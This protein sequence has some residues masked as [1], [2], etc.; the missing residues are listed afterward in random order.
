MNETEAV[1]RKFLS[2]LI[3]M[4]PDIESISFMARLH[5]GQG[6]EM[7]LLFIAVGG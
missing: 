2:F 6:P 1:D 3:G 7:D 5:A 4:P